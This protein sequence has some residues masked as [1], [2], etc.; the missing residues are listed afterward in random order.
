MNNLQ[1][2]PR[3]S[4]IQIVY[5][6]GMRNHTGRLEMIG[7]ATA[8]IAHDINN[9]LFLIVNH[10]SFADV[11]AARIAAERC[12]AL[13][14]SLLAYCK[15]EHIRIS[16]IDPIAFLQ[17]FVQELHLP[18][19]I[20]VVVE[21]PA[22]LPP[23]SA[24][25]LMLT[26]ALTNLVSNACSAMENHGTVRIT[27][28]PRTIEIGDTGPGVPLSE[29]KRIFEPFYSTKGMQG[30]GLGLAI[31]REIMSQHGGSVTI[32]SDAGTGAKFRLHFRPGK[33]KG[34]YGVTAFKTS[35]RKIAPAA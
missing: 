28:S 29:R 10:L 14:A 19:S 5:A 8:G 31:V 23:I 30:T 26:R 2:Y 32:I 4:G 27:A 9:H 22:S 12:A 21:T 11:N 20:D 13:T 15:G 18:E 17:N 25:P 1:T 6:R 7:S 3:R 35:P 33:R 16:C 24:N 34:A